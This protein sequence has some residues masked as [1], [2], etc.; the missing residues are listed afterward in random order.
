MDRSRRR[1]RRR[2][3]RCCARAG[4]RTPCRRRRLERLGHGRGGRTQHATAVPTLVPSERAA[5]GRRRRAAAR[6][7]GLTPA[8]RSAHTGHPSCGRRAGAILGVRGARGRRAHGRRR[9][10]RLSQRASGRQAGALAGLHRRVRRRVVLLV[11]VMPVRRV[12]PSVGSWR[13]GVAARGRA[14]RRA[15]R[16]GWLERP[17]DGRERGRRAAL[18]PVLSRPRAHAPISATAWHRRAQRARA[19]SRACARARCRRN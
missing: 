1:R 11:G 16:G 19:C 6:R 9:A 10:G 18:S 4:G 5:R 3:V 13:G 14:R 7:A 12:F 15:L 8:T 17:R 2:A